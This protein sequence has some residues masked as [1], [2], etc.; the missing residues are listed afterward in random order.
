MSYAAEPYAQ[1]VEDLLLSLTGG[2]ARERFVFL[3]ENAPFSLSPPGPVVPSTLSVFGQVD[4]TFHRFVLD[5]DFSLSADG[6]LVWL[7]NPDGTRAAD[8][9]WPDEGTAFFAN[10]DH[11][12]PSGA[13]PRLNDRNPGSVVRLLSE[14]FA[15]EYAVVSRQLE[16]VYQAGFLDTATGR[17]LDNLVRLVGLERRD[18][19]FATGTVVFSRS[20]PAPADIFISEGTR[21][22]TA[23][24]PLAEFETTEDR[25]LHRGSL[26]VEV[27]IRARDN[28]ATGV[29][30]ARAVSVINRPILGIE[31]AENPLGTRLDGE[32]ETDEALRARAR[33]ALEMA[34]QGTVGALKGAL[35]T[36]PGV[37]EKDIL[38]EEDPL[39]RPGLV[40]VS[41]A[42]ELT[43][44]QA[45][46]AVD[47]IESTRPVGVRVLH[48]LSV[49]P[50]PEAITPSVNLVSE[51]EGDPHDSIDGEGLFS[52]VVARVIVVPGSARLSAQD[53]TALKTLAEDTL[54]DTVAEAGVGEPVVYNRV[55]G[56]LMGIE[57]VVDVAL[58]LYP[59][60]DLTGP[61]HRNVFPGRTRRPSVATKDG[62]SIEVRVAGELLGLDVSV[63]VTLIGAGALGDTAANLDAAR[64]QIMAQLRDGVGSLTGLS[65]SA[66][67]G[68]ITAPETFTVNSLSYTGEYVTAGVRLN[69]T[70]PTL[71]LTPQELAWIRNVKVTTP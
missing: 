40:T 50:P 57:G 47:L 5:T 44:A 16:G 7:A 19:T 10:Y 25:T 58:E 39:T 49:S 27:P 20:S 14:S 53:R 12:G 31:T 1:F 21:L 64:Y 55:V 46:R 67:R 61:R 34:G 56:A 33:R 45:E 65:A 63:N 48:H 8:A 28:G 43:A 71:T 23:E 68:L 17:D 51:M 59:P 42:A 36:L 15:R 66:L 37:R 62:G 11:R 29:A 41:I 52:P 30:P 38:L 9:V 2:V 22:S 26:S 60:T 3:P 70:S 32:P 35:A 54:R 69:G 4:G 6:T 18:R 13:A 24:P